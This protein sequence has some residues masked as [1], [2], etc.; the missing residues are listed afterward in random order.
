MVKIRSR[1]EGSAS[2]S[3]ID[4]RCQPSLSFP[5]YSHF[6]VFVVKP[7]IFHPEVLFI[8]VWFLIF[9]GMARV[10]MRTPHRIRHGFGTNG[11][12]ASPLASNCQKIRHLFK[13]TGPA[14]E[15]AWQIPTRESAQEHS[16]L[17]K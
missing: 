5:A 2:W 10:V 13:A 16:R 17:C 3:K 15:S 4:R 1:T 7:S 9:C 14:D 8:Y 12:Y 11:Y 6:S